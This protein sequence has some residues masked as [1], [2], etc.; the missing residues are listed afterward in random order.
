M[1]HGERKEGMRRGLGTKKGSNS[2]IFCIMGFAK[3]ALSN[4][5]KP[6]KKFPAGYAYRE[7]YW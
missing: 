3:L 7:H 4:M 5:I 6:N 2:N 1:G